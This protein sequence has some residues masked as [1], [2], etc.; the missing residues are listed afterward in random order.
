MKGFASF[1]LPGVIAG[2]AFAAMP[3]IAQQQDFSKVEE[4]ATPLGHDMFAITGAG[5]N[6]TVAVGSDAVIVVDTQYAP[7]YD[8]LKAKIAEVSGGKPIRYVID[9]H[10]HGDHTGGNASFAHDGA[11]LVAH[12]NVGKRLA[13]PL[14]GMN[15]QTPPPAPAEA[16]PKES[17][18][19]NSHQV[20]IAGVTAD[21]VHPMPAHTDGDS[22]VFWKTENVISTGDIVGSASYPNIDVASGGGIDGMIAAV[23]YLLAHSDANT[24]IVPGHGP[25]FDRTGLMGYRQMLATAR[26]RIAKAKASGMSEQQ[27]A[28][29]H[30]L[31][32][33]DTKWNSSGG[34]SRFPRLVYQ[35]IH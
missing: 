7:L 28:D 34:P 13:N 3:A 24:K 31:A 1:V 6:T 35:S 25:V 26:E 21:L 32:D 23:D 11:I 30:L 9:T 18:S 4:Q 5:G 33:L 14:P 29:A 22:F 19:G 27:V 17:Y 10:Y 16:M 8:R 2:L 12:E 20:K 15:G